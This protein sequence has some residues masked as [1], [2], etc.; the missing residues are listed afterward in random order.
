MLLSYVRLMISKAS[1][2]NTDEERSKPLYGI[3]L[4]AHF[5]FLHNTNF[6]SNYNVNELR[7][8]RKIN[9]GSILI[10]NNKQHNVDKI[11]IT[12]KLIR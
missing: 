1:E 6:S 7:I 9:K 12:C 3:L 4:K 2:Q 10:Y 5:I 11:S 8:S